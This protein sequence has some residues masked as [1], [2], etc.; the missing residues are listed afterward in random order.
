MDERSDDNMLTIRV[1]LI[2]RSFLLRVI[3]RAGE[4]FY[5]DCMIEIESQ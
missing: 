3:T 4:T 2:I 1:A 5:T